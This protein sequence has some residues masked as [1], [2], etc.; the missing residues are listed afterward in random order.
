[1]TDT[2][3]S[4]EPVLSPEIGAMAPISGDKTARRRRVVRVAAVVIVLAAVVAG[5]LAS[6][7]RP[8]GLARTRTALLD[9]K[10]FVNGPAAGTAFA[11]ASEWLLGDGKSCQQHHGN[12]D[13]R[14]R[15]RMSAAAYSGVTAFIVVKCTAPGVYRARTAML[16][17]VRS[18]ENFD[19][20][21]MGTLATPSQPPL[22]S[23]Q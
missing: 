3:T 5:G 10:R 18:I 9:N 7:P 1:M 6:R 21:P 2:T 19:R 12:A 15:I 13:P 20:A 8:S 17:Y 23:C 14:C 4:H 11:Q 22:A 16:G